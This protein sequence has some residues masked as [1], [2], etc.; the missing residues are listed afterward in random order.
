[1][2]LLA[3]LARFRLRVRRFSERRHRWRAAPGQRHRG[4]VAGVAQVTARTTRPAYGTPITASM[5]VRDIAAA[6]GVSTAELCRWKAMADLGNA[7]F[8][9]R[10]A[11]HNAEG[12]HASAASILAMN[13]PVPAR[14]RVQRAAAIYRTMTPGERVEFIALVGGGR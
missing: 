12:R 6:L 4:V 3:P 8:E 7:E 5:S 10:L 13:G 11:A 9:R 1:M 2:A 14:G